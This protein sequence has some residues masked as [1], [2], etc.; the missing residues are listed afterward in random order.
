[1]DADRM[2]RP[3]QPV[4]KRRYAR[5]PVSLAVVGRTRQFPG[6]A[7]S[8]VVRDV[9]CGGLMAEFPVLMVSGSTLGLE[10][11]T[12]WGPMQM[13]GKVVWTAVAEGIVRHGVAFAEPREE[14]FA[15]DLFITGGL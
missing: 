3:S 13:D 2:S 8:G 4:G 5:F 10:L 14:D 7:I 6:E 11:Q 15:L 12:R 1:M 9:G